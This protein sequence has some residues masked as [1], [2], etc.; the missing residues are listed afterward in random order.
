MTEA[1]ST[2]EQKERTDYTDGS[3]WGAI[4]KMGLPSMF[5]FLGQHF[6]SLVNTFWVSRLEAGESAIAAITFFINMMFV[7]FS[8]NHLIGPGSVAVISRRY[9]EKEYFKTEKA[10]KETIFLK[11]FFGVIFSALGLF[12]LRD[13]LRFVGAEG[14]TLE[15]AVAYGAIFMAGMPIMFATYSLFTAMRGVANPQMAMILMFGSTILNAILDPILMFGWLGLPALGI[16]GAAIASVISFSLAFVV[17]LYLFFF[18]YTNVRLHIKGHEPMSIESMWT[19][20]KI[21]VASWLGEMSFSLSRFM[22]TPLIA[23]FGVSVVAAF[24]IGM[25]VFGLG[26]AILVGI[27]LGLSSLIGHTVGSGKLDRAKST[28]DKAIAFGVVAMAALG[29]LI[30]IFV[31]PILE[32]FF[33]DPVAIEAGVTYLRTI[34]FSFPFFGALFMI[35]SIHGG[36]GLNTPVMVISILQA[37]VLQVLPVLVAV[38]YFGV[39]Q[40]VVWWIMALSGVI[41]SIGFYWYYRQGKWL[42][43]RV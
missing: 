5:G 33:T 28:G 10:I 19:L 16:R 2:V 3:V 6:Y 14:E 18:D 11:L 31:R 42:T 35:E 13:A 38:Q 8:I 24:G 27:G 29:V 12:F 22:I 7:F 34:A 30:A 40:V 23:H 15:L 43:V 4:I 26:I 41:S 20:I 37:W 1:A 32:I 17:G 39:G 36:V 25:Q 21:G 9:G